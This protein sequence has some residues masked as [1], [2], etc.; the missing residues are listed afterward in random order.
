[1]NVEE[2]SSVIF[3]I[4]GG[5]NIYIHLLNWEDL[6]FILKLVDIYNEWTQ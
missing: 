5:V 1:M 6:Y 2:N 4:Q 3:D